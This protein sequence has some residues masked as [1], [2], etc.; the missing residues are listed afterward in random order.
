MSTAPWIPIEQPPEDGRPVVVLCPLPNYRGL[1][2]ESPEPYLPHFIAGAWPLKIN[3]SLS[4]THWTPI[5]GD[6]P[7]L[8]GSRPK[9]SG[10]RPDTPGQPDG[11]RR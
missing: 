3:F 2:P 1:P 10:D 4:P 7:E 5:P 11:A 9:V 6:L 8:P